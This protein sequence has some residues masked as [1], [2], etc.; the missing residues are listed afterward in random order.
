MIDHPMVQAGCKFCRAN[1]LLKGDV[2]AENDEAY[3]IESMFGN[4]NYLIMP[5][6][7][8]EA[9]AELHD[10]WWRGVKD[11]VPKVPNL[12]EDYNLSFNIGAEAGQTMKHLHLW[13]IPR[14]AGQ[15]ASMTGLAGLI[16]KFN[17][18]NA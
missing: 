3:L 17:T 7:H 8:A 16:E 18:T 15:P 9:I 12:T 5:N 11:L 6:Y 4:N 13:V 10:N 14:F 2:I 1:G